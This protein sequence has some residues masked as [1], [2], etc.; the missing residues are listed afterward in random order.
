MKKGKLSLIVLLWVSVGGGVSISTTVQAKTTNKNVPNS[1]K[2]TQTVQS[3]KITEKDI[4]ECTKLLDKTAQTNKVSQKAIEKD[5]VAIPSTSHTK[6]A[7]P[8]KKPAE[9]QPFASD[10]PAAIAHLTGKP[11][12]LAT[13]AKAKSTT[14][15]APQHLVNKSA[16][17][18]NT[19]IVTAN[20]SKTTVPSTTKAKVTAPKSQ[21]TSQPHIELFAPSDNAQADFDHLEGKSASL[22]NLQKIPPTNKPSKPVIEKTNTPKA[23][24]KET[25]TTKNT[26]VTKSSS[27]TKKP[28]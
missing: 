11:V 3:Y 18:S 21:Q 14:V 1:H 27:T 9:V 20:A 5:I 6:I 8:L 12:K 16:T 4:A 15:P 17:P 25:K 13:P 23:T 19:Q 26:K 28:S 7:E 24:Q 10:D 2:K 22:E